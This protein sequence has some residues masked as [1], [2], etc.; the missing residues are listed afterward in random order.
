MK[1]RQFD[2]KVDNAH[3]DYGMVAQELQ[4]VA[5]EA[6]WEP[7]NEEDM[8]GVD[9]SKLVPMLIKEIQTLRSRVATLE[10]NEG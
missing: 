8:K 7:E 9:Y 1:V 10:A 6:V 4:T 3:Q 2:W 5:P